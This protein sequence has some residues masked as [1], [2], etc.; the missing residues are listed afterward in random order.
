[1]NDKEIN[2]STKQQTKITICDKTIIVTVGP[3][4]C[5]KSHFIENNILPQLNNYFLNIKIVSVNK[6]RELITGKSQDLISQE[7]FYESSEGAYLMTKSEISHLV[8][9]PTNKFADIIIVD[10]SGLDVNFLEEIFNLGKENGYNICV[11][12]FDFSNNSD[13][14][15]YSKDKA[16]SVAQK[17]I[18]WEKI[19]DFLLKH[20]NEKLTINKISSN[21]NKFIFD[22]TSN[23]NSIKITNFNKIFVIS[24]VLGDSETFNQI[25]EKINSI[26]YT[27]YDIF[28]LM[29]NF[30][31]ENMEILQLIIDFLKKINTTVII[32]KG[33]ME[34][35]LINKI[36][37]N[38]DSDLSINDLF[39]K[40]TKKHVDDFEYI[41]NMSY[42]HVQVGKYEFTTSLCDRQNIE[43]CKIYN[44]DD[45]D[46]FLNYLEN[47]SYFIHVCS[48]PLVTKIHKHKSNILIG[49]C[50]LIV[51]FDNSKLINTKFVKS[52]NNYK[53]DFSDKSNDLYKKFVKIDTNDKSVKIREINYEN[54]SPRILDRINYMLTHKI[55]YISGTI[56]P[57]NKHK[58]TGQLECIET[59]LE[60]YHNSYKNTGKL[61]I[62][63]KYM[64]SRC[65]FYYFVNNK[66][67]SFGVSRNGFLIKLPQTVLFKIYDQ[68]TEKLKLFDEYEGSY[69]IIIDGE[70]MPWSALGHDLIDNQF[71]SLHKSALKELKYL[72]DSDFEIEQS[73][74]LD[75]YSSSNFEKES[76]SMKSKELSSK[77]K[78]Y[79]TFKTLKLNKN[80]Y[81]NVDQ[82]IDD[83]EKFKKQVELFGKTCE[84]DEI[85]YKPFNILKFAYLENQSGD[86][87]NEFSNST[88][89]IYNS[90]IKAYEILSDD[91]TITLDLS[92]KLNDNIQ[93]LKI[94]IEEKIKP[95]DYEGIIIKP[96][97]INP[98]FAP[99][100][101]V[102]NSEYLRIIYGP[103]YLHPDKFERLIEKKN[104]RDKLESSIKEY[105]IGIKMLEIPFD[106]LD[107]EMIDD[108]K[109]LYF[110][111]LEEEE[112]EKQY[113][114]AL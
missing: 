78:K 71:K 109:N 13:Y 76:S 88:E 63:I 106:K 5:G 75:E 9:Y 55:N 54:L 58:S 91:K 64:G 74:L 87:S 41:W 60:Y 102:R 8:K 10:S 73:K 18:M 27:K 93:K 40:M 56:S 70:L 4:G 59:A 90:N 7:E 26:N 92:D 103:D 44:S 39:N 68:L 111:F 12:M 72:K 51:V 29:G 50:P 19:W 66:E 25:L 61:S 46:S 23:K 1:M 20:K 95:F 37:K 47:S 69:L 77:F 38:D 57:S 96:D 2:S 21:F 28:I 34:K 110:T 94:F 79:E 48:Y 33:H 84:L 86:Q 65:Q 53:N 67:L 35:K 52:L 82:Q 101:K 16:R 22:Y 85:H 45:S 14:L 31:G 112:R 104:I 105:L 11:C 97:V 107:N 80:K 114:K 49:Q 17:K 108:M 32:L 99:C 6:K 36:I 113:D 98:N 30:I 42:S 3:T 43:F 81:V 100:L 83:M 15:K 24:S 89:I 62:Q